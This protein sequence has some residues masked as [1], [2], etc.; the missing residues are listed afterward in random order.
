M[1]A[2]ISNYGYKVSL[3]YLG[4]IGFAIMAIGILLSKPRSSFGVKYISRLINFLLT[5]V[6]TGKPKYEMPRTNKGLVL[7]NT[8][9]LT[10]PMCLLLLFS[11][12][13]PFGYLVPFYL[14]PS[15]V[16]FN[17]FCFRLFIGTDNCSLSLCITVPLPTVYSVSIGL[18][19]SQGSLIVAVGSGVNAVSRVVFGLA[20][21]RWM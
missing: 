7:V 20:A 5:L 14:I 15:R 1:Q 18:E 2:L 9:L 21:D 12:L 13:V 11:F 10:L 4:I 17:L 6:Y 8:S 3:R 16:L 19:A